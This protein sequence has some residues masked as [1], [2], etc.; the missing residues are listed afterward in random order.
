MKVLIP[1]RVVL[2]ID[3]R[4]LCVVAEKN[5]FVAFPLAFIVNKGQAD[6]A[7]V[8]SANFIY[9]ANLFE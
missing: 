1:L 7:M 8:S 5:A 2:K 9:N 6:M 4:S 3:G